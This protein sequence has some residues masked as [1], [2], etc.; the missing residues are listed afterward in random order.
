MTVCAPTASVLVT[1]VAMPVLNVIGT[2]A[3]PSTVKITVPIAL[4]GITLA[5]NVTDCPAVE[6]LTLEIRAVV[7]AA[8]ATVKLLLV[9]SIKP[10]AFAVSVYVPAVLTLIPLNVATPLT[11]ATSN[12]PLSVPLLIANTTGKV[13]VPTTLL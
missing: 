10:L 7:V 3:V 11:A 12:V 13:F 1:S 6:G 4:A 9:T 8:C 2:L 5:A